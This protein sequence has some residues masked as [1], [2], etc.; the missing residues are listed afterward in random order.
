MKSGPYSGM[1][2]IAARGPVCDIRCEVS[3]YGRHNAQNHQLV[4][5]SGKG[6]LGMTGVWRSE[7]EE[8]DLN[9]ARHLDHSDP[10]GVYIP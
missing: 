4:T 5:L 6:T 1:I 8:A 2:D 7:S 3:Y 10:G 9:E